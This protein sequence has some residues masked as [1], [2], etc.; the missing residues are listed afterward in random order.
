M[1]NAYE[2]RGAQLNMESLYIRHDVISERKLARL[3]PDRPVSFR[4]DQ[5][6]SR[7]GTTLGRCPL[8]LRSSVTHRH[9]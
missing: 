8:G 6:V 3:N 1:S 2:R 5:A 7:F 4:A 9:F